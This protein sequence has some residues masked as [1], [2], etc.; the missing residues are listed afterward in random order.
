MF[1]FDEYFKNLTGI[2]SGPHP[3]QKNLAESNICTNRLIRIPTGFGKTYG[4]LS[5]W[6]WHRI[7]HTNQNWPRRLVWCLPMRV[8][9]EQTAMAIRNALRGLKILWENGSHENQVGVHTLMGGSDAGEWHLFPE[10]CAVLIGTQD[11][12]LSRAMNRGYGSPR[13]RWPMEFG[14]LNQDCLWVMDEVQL[15]DVGL[16]TASQL[17]AFREEDRKAGRMIKFCAT[18]WMSATLQAGWLLKS[19]DTL[20][21]VQKRDLTEISEPDRMGHLWNSVKKPFRLEP[22]K[23]CHEIA[24]LVS[25]Y[26]D[27][28]AGTM[29][30]ILVVVN[31]VDRA[32]EIYKALQKEKALEQTEADLRLIHSRFR[33][34]ERKVW[35][36][37]FLH[38]KACSAQAN[39]IIVST[40]VIEAGVDISADL[41][42]TELAP[43]ASLVQRIGRCARWG[44]S[45]LVTIVDLYSDDEKAAAPYAGDDI[46][47][48]REALR[49]F[50]S[51]D[52]SPFRLEA[53]EKENPELCEKLYR[54]S[55]Q[56]LLL[57]HEIED[58]FDT[59]PD[60]SGAD[61]DISRFIRS[62]D[63]RDLHVFWS[64]MPAYGG[65]EPELRPVR[66]ELCAVPFLKAREWLCGKETKTVRNPKLKDKMRA[67]VWDWLDGIWRRAK[68]ADLIPGR[69]VLV[70][71]GCG[72]YDRSIG[73]CPESQ[74]PVSPLE[75][76]GTGLSE[77]SDMELESESSS[78]HNAWQTI[79]V[80]G[81]ETGHIARKI[82][83]IISPEHEAL[84]GIVGRWH[85][86]G[87]AHPAFNN[88]INSPERPDRRDLAKAPQNAWLPLSQLYPMNGEKRRAG[89]R[90]ELVSVVA[91]FAVVQGNNPDHPALLGPWRSFLEASGFS[92][93]PL[94]EP[95]SSHSPLE[96]EILDLNSESFDLAAYLI[97]AHHGKIRMTWH[98][99]PL[100][101]A[102]ND[103]HLRIM[104]VKDG[105]FIPSI[106]LVDSRNAYSRLPGFKVDLSPANA[107]LNPS[108]GSGWTERVLRLLN[109][110]GPFALAWLEAIFRAA[111]QRASR[112]LVKDDLIDPEEMS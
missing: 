109:Q 32:I 45:A 18:W 94:V 1:S 63:E 78:V 46:D 56:H 60:L 58:L 103:E 19:P 33:P 86:V 83:R 70:E 28:Q 72:G 12:L 17:Q 49:R 74:K 37:E 11:M 111:D 55:P 96:Q 76:T 39:R 91:M 107:G 52:F 61:I 26:C 110:Y 36:E 54:F 24:G 10:E 3:W 42:I 82:A 16:A 50:D 90:H 40:Q 101:Q 62:G 30:T 13:A 34:I 22:P 92:P 88:S 47:A 5:A 8:L 35:S 68:R 9:V 43:W 80:H 100:D 93:A 108:T 41:L 44:G 66:D 51:K 102:A 21:M 87:K 64:K 67:W 15:M 77:L 89:F 98:A 69:T 104:G 99:S 71:A 59:T 53:F 2:R 14:L 57:R 79:A 20:E 6:L 75:K 7:Y 73:W 84:L 106:T 112:L 48:A 38:R 105:D 95:K 29:G 23:S 85:D 97:C 4:I 81:R 25:E 65:P 31:T 27:Q